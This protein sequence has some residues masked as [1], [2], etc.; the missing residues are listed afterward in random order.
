MLQTPIDADDVGS[1]MYDL[2]AALYPI[3]RSIT[4]DGIRRSLDILCRHIPLEIHQVPTGTAVFDWTV[5]PEWNITDAYIKNSFG[6]KIVDFQRSNLHVLNYSIPIRAKVSLAELKQHLYSIPEHPEWIPYRTSYYQE[7][8][9]FCVSHRLLESLTDGE[10]EVCIDSSL[11][12]GYLTFGE[13]YLPGQGQDEILLSCHCC[14]PSM[15]NDNLSG[16]ALATFLAKALQAMQRRYSYRFL[17]VPA[18]I[19]AITWLAL[20]EGNT[21]RIKH[22]LVI[23]CVG[24]SGKLTFKKSRQGTAEIDRAVAHVLQQSGQPFEILDF[25]PDGYDERQYCSPSFNLP[26]GRLTRTPHGRFPEY[27]TSADNLDLMDPYSLGDSLSKYLEVL[28]L[29]E[30]NKKYVNTNPKG[31]P[32][33]SKRNLYS[34]I[35]GSQERKNRESALL[36]VLSFSDGEHTLLDIAERAG[37]QF[38]TIREAAYALESCGLL[39]Q[40]PIQT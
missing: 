29:L 19:G 38:S 17:F 5:P 20:N 8:W 1:R 23:A 14:H 21:P 2:I 24:D 34:T 12:D 16:I 18:T 3:C 26:V 10:Y 6:E 11:R 15:C 25:S 9:G 32:Q 36:W 33:L 7:N 37:I 28:D 13:Y 22:G 35:G 31:E 30:H 4:G 39:M 27:H 40:V